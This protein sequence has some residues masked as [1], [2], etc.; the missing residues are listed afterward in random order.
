MA[1]LEGFMA[2]D[3][4][5]HIC[6]VRGCT[7]KVIGATVV[8]MKKKGLTFDAYQFWCKKHYGQVLSNDE[9]LKAKGEGNG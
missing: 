6:S 3:D 4:E 8:Q 9:R 5:V 7:D 1:H 2:I